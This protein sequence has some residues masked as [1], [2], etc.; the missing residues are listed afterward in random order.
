MKGPS[1]QQAGLAVPQPSATASCLAVSETLMGEA[2]CLL[3]SPCFLWDV[4]KD[5][6]FAKNHSAKF[7]WRCRTSLSNRQRERGFPMLAFQLC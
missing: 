2:V 3:P 4:S 7:R 6:W 5:Q 1:F